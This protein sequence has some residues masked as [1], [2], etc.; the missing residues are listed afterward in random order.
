M[1]PR[2]ALPGTHAR[3]PHVPSLEPSVNQTWRLSIAPILNIP[4]IILCM[5]ASN[6][7]AVPLAV[8]TDEP[9]VGISGSRARWL[10]TLHPSL[11]NH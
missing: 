4:R 6:M 3:E 10:F 9:H 8:V 2:N 1:G 11:P 7:Q 5:H